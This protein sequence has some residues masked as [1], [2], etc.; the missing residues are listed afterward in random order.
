VFPSIEYI[1]KHSNNKPYR[2]TGPSGSTERSERKGEG[3]RE[4][5]VRRE[6]EIHRMNKIIKQQSWMQLDFYL[7]TQD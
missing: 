7:L 3:G 2:N 1:N 6:M 5:F 4:H